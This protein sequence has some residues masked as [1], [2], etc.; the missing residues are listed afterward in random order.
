MMMLTITL[1][2]SVE[3]QLEADN[4]YELVKTRIE[5]HPEVSLTGHTS[6]HF[7]AYVPPEEPD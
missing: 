1:R 2:K 5:D 4:L 3:D 6:N 7:A